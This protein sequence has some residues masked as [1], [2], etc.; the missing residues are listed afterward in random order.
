MNRVV[1]KGIHVRGL[2]IQWLGKKGWGVPTPVKCLLVLPLMLFDTGYFSSH[3]L[4]LPLVLQSLRDSFVEAGADTRALGCWDL[5]L[6]VRWPNQIE[7]QQYL[8]H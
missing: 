7:Q 1:Q 2:A 4:A 6:R 3:F 8:L 5:H